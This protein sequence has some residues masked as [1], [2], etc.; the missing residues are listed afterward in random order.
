MKH[1]TAT[2]LNPFHTVNVITSPVRTEY[3]TRFSVW[4]TLGIL[5]SIQLAE[6]RD[7]ISDLQM[8]SSAV[9]CTHH[10]SSLLLHAYVDSP[11]LNVHS[12]HIASATGPCPTAQHLVDD[13]KHMT[14]IPP[15]LWHGCGPCSMCGQDISCWRGR[16][17]HGCS[18][19]NRT[20][21]QIDSVVCGLFSLGSL[22][23]ADQNVCIPICNTQNDSVQRSINNVEKKFNINM[24]AIM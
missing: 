13:L 14:Q 8:K 4:V 18:W 7:K 17:T 19:S 23:T 9:S 21:A 12:F 10:A 2:Q 6:H 15:G 1:A 5:S 22:R 11:S 24:T 3:Q 20:A 16:A